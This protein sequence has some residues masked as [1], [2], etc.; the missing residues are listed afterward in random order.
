MISGGAARFLRRL[1]IAVLVLVTVGGLTLLHFSRNS[2]SGALG[3][4]GLDTVQTARFMARRGGF[5][6]QVIRPLWTERILPND[7]GSMPNVAQQPLYLGIGAFALR[8]TKQ[9]APGTG[10]RIMVLLTLVLFVLSAGAGYLLARRLFGA[11]TALLAVLFYVFGGAALPLVLTPHPAPLASLLFTL[12]LFALYSLDRIA[13]AGEQDRKV[14]IWWAVGAGLFYGLLFLTLYSTLILLPFL[15]FYLI[16]ISRRDFRIP[17]LFLVVMLAI[18]SPFLL[19]NFRLTRNPLYNIR[20]NEI[21]MNT[22]TYPGYGLYRQ[23]SLPVT[24]TYY[25]TTHVGEIA[26]KAAQNLGGLYGQAPSVLGILVFPLFLGAGLTRFTDNR[27]NRLRGL[28]YFL[29]PIHL[30]GLSLFLP[31]AE[32]LSVF[33]IYAPFATALS[34][35]FLLAI[36]RAR[37]LPR[38]F[39]RTVL[40]AWI[41]LALLPGGIALFAAPHPPPPP[42]EVFTFLNGDSPAATAWRTLPNTLIACDSPWEI[43]Y[44]CD[45][46]AVWLPA[47]SVVASTMEER[48]GRQLVGVVL[49]STLP[50]SY[51]D[52]EARPWVG[53]YSRV[54][55]VT[56]LATTLPINL[57]RQVIGK[58]ELFFPPQVGPLLR[59][60]GP[61][62]VPE[63]DGNFSIL[64]WRTADR[65]AGRGGRG[66]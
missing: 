4:D 62:P 2:V 8:L 9:T 51:S 44:R 32:C 3:A 16:R 21:M 27:I 24:V 35:S 13:P 52:P 36:V 10:D 14:S 37:N 49:T 6:T 46:P 29:I 61:V 17:A 60:F 26:R 53:T 22:E 11:Q 7:D 42:S 65:P 59:N 48:S 55:S 12:V 43:A 54:L 1:M 47:D 34:A 50:Y 5:T 15:L 30:L 39:E 58:I 63:Q 28:V 45:R 23:A 33:L 40:A 20:L 38:F 57:S 66:N 56:Q 31:Y 19:R 41:G 25:V 18:I 64:F